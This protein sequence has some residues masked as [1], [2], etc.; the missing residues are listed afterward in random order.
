[1]DN[2]TILICY[3]GSDAAALGREFEAG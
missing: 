2:G 1:M 3:D